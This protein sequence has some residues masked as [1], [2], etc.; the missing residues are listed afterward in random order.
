MKPAPMAAV[1]SLSG[2]AGVLAM[3]VFGVPAGIAVMLVVGAM[4]GSVSGL[5][6]AYLRTS[7]LVVTLGML[8][9]AQATAR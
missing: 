3:K 2:V 4:A 6:I 1:L 7:P 5:I 9:I 8:S